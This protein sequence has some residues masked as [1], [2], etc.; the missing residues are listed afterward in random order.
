MEMAEDTVT[1]V[2][3]AKGGSQPAFAELVRIHQASVRSYL[4]RFLRDVHVSDDVAQEVFLV[5]F[6]QLE[7]YQ[8]A[9]S[10]QSWLIGIARN[11]ARMYLRG[12][13]RRR[14]RNQ[15]FFEAALAQWQAGRLEDNTRSEEDQEQVLAALRSCINGLPEASQTVVYQYYFR[16][17][18]TDSIAEMLSKRAGAVRMMLTRVRSALKE[19]VASKLNRLEAE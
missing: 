19:C 17:Q 10:F 14:R 6:R 4:S 12:E 7:D 3:R 11:R 18:S 16:K 1:L 5:A 2:E 13:T 9:A 8:G 15:Q